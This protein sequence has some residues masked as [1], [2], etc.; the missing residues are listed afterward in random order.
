MLICKMELKRYIKKKYTNKFRISLK[1]MPEYFKDKEAVAKN[2][3]K[4]PVI[5]TVFVKEE[6]ELNYYLTVLMPGKIGKQYFMTRGHMHKRPL[7][8]TYM[9]VGGNAWLLMKKGKEKSLTK[10]EKN[11]AYIVPGDFAHRVINPGKKEALFLTITPKEAG[12]IY[13]K[14]LF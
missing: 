5:Y 6:K 2:L 4:N 12:H 7:S 8:E 10:M 11:I 13:K 1:D 14:N 3:R 9:L